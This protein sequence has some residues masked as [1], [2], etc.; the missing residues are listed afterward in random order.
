MTSLFRM[1]SASIIHNPGGPIAI[2]FN[3]LEARSKNEGKNS[4]MERFAN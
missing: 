2:P 3:R 4:V 1:P